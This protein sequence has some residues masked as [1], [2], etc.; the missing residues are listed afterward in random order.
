MSD[1]YI[2]LLEELKNL[3]DRKVTVIPVLI[4]GLGTIPKELIKRLEDLKIRG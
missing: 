4:V 2:D 1:K 3:W